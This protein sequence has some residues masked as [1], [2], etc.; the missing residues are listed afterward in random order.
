MLIIGRAV[1]GMGGSGIQNGAV[2]IISLA[3]PMER[4][5]ML[6]GVVIGFAQLG[7]VAGP[8][9]GG[10]LTE[11]AGWRWCV[12]ILSYNAALVLGRT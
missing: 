10:V 4:R 11:F 6:M 3:A 1:A 2:T 5:P 8:L 9:V 7:L 12:E